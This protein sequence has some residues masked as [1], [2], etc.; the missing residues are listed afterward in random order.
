MTARKV[1][2]SQTV[3]ALACRIGQHWL[4]D[5]EGARERNVVESGAAG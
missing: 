3:N 4:I 2:R 1:P 5:W